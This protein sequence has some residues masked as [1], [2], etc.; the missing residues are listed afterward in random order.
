MK[1]LQIYK[2]YYPPVKGGIE[3]HLHLLCHGLKR[4]GIK[5]RVL[6]SNTCA[7]WSR[8]VLDG[9]EVTKVPQV[10]RI[11]SAP[12]APTFP[13]SSPKNHASHITGVPLRAAPQPLHFAPTPFHALSP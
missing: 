7:K 1:I 9:I 6:V 2:D 10:G 3:G 12:I 5:V 11:S 13:H 4:R 8:E